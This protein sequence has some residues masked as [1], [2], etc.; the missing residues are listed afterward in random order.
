MITKSKSRKMSK[1]AAFAPRA[2]G[3]RSST[4][5]RRKAPPHRVVFK[6]LGETFA[7]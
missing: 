3:R 7:M 6:D 4:A 1:R 2:A 5:R